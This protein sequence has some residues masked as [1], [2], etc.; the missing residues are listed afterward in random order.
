[1]R[2]YKVIGATLWNRNHTH[3][4][5]RLGEMLVAAPSRYAGPVPNPVKPNE[6]LQKWIDENIPNVTIIHYEWA[7][8]LE[9][10]DEKDYLKYMLAWG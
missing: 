6:E 4:S 2:F 8:N 10:R 3:V 7:I 1:M 9:F 5:K